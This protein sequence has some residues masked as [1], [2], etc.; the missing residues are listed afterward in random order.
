MYLFCMKHL[1]L[2]LSIIVGTLSPICAYEHLNFRTIDIEKGLSDNL[3]LSITQDQYGFIWLST[4]NG[5]NRYD[6]YNIKHYLT[7]DSGGYHNNIQS[8]DE[9]KAGNLWVKTPS[10]YYYYNRITDRIE[11]NISILLTPL[12]ISTPIEKLVVDENKNLWCASSDSIYLHDFNTKTTTIHTAPQ[13]ERILRIV[14]RDRHAYL[15]CESGNIYK[16]NN[17]NQ[18]LKE[19]TGQLSDYEHHEMYIDGDYNLWIYT[20]FSP[21][22]SIQH[23]NTLTNLWEN[24][25]KEFNFDDSYIVQIIDDLKGNI[26]I[27]TDNK[28]VFIYQAD[29][30]QLDH[31]A[32]QKNQKNSLP[33]NHLGCLYKDNQD[34]IWIGTSKRGAA[35]VNLDKTTFQPLNICAQTDIN[36]LVEDSK[37]NLWLGSDGEGLYRHHPQRKEMESYQKSNSNIPSDVIVC[38]FADSKERLWIGTFGEGIC[39][40]QNN[41][42]TSLKELISDTISNIP[43]YIRSINE[44]DAGNIWI[45]TIVDGL[46]CYTPNGKIHRYTTSNSILPTGSITDLLYN[47]NTLYVA[48]SNGM[49]SID[50]KRGTMNPVSQNSSI[51]QLFADL[52]ITTLYRDSRGL[53]WIGGQ[54]G[55]CVYD[56]NKESIIYHTADKRWITA[57]VKSI[58]EDANHNI[59]I[60]T[61][62]GISNIIV[63]N[64]PEKSIP[65]FRYYHYGEEDGI[66]KQSF[67]YHS[68]LSMQDKSILVGGTNGVIQIH[69]KALKT[70]VRNPKVVFTNLYLSNKAVATGEELP[71]GRVPLKK[72]IQL[73]DELAVDYTDNFTIEVSGMNYDNQHNTAYLYRLNERE[74]W[75]KVSDNKIHFN[76]LHP[77]KYQLEVKM[78]NWNGDWSSESSILPIVVRPPFWQSAW[79]YAMYAILLI[80]GLFYLIY[81]LK[82]RQL[83][84]IEMQRKEMEAIQKNEMDEAKLRFF[85]NISHDLRT[86]LSLI[87]TPLEKMIGSKGKV[88]HE[89]I[90]MVHRNA[91][92]LMNQVSQLLD[93]RKLEEK[94]TEL[95]ASLGNLSLFV[96]EICDDFANAPNDK[97]ILLELDIPTSDVQLSFDRNKMR[98]ILTNLLSNAYKYN[99]TNGKVNV[100]IDPY[101]NKEG[102]SFVRI[103]VEDTGIGIGGENKEKVFNRFFQEGTSTDNIG[104]GL[105][106][107]IVKQFTTMHGGVI[108][109]SDNLPQGTRFTL[110]FPLPT[111]TTQDEARIEATT[112]STLKTLLIVEDN[113]DFRLFLSNSLK[114]H[115][116]ILTACN[117][118]EGMTQLNKNT[119]DIV[120]SDVMMPVMDGLELCSKI[121]N[122]I[123]LSHIPVILLTARTREE[124]IV[125]GLKEGADEYITKP[126]NLDILLLRIQKLLEWKTANHKKFATVDVSP[127]EITISSLDEQLI[128]K[129]LALVEKNMDNTEFTVEDL[130]N[131]VGMTRGHLYKKLMSITGKSPFDFICTLRIKRGKQLLEQSQLSISEIAYRVGFSPKQFA[132]YFKNEYQ[133]LPSE[134]KKRENN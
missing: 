113:S 56:E 116:N 61:D 30:K 58:A 11:K 126:F 128:N 70:I 104:N 7:P 74:D 106:L 105:G 37:G 40:L 13:D 41:R 129:C 88:N 134:Y 19:T 10:S 68:I 23:Y 16:A 14:S 73:L 32:K 120:I 28:G 103:E 100:S 17:D 98:R 54:N 95:N 67:N 65:E 101:T 31:I 18:F 125:E 27:A 112:D 47:K 63:V 50:T 90:V 29:E 127:A 97:N 42:F 62:A 110:T 72:N 35:L 48:T 77:G 115:F 60:T 5:V 45:G 76:R 94:E 108:E 84:K 82:H 9:D 114:K 91:K 66:D 4:S 22:K 92:L 79:A 118:K 43:Q 133:C 69:P 80:S 25:F 36:S 64:D 33:D 89:E 121:K 86:P 131:E 49:V 24:P 99:V 15:L 109:V 130:S 122:S 96:R 39:Y 85:T 78:I 26:W 55:L 3:I 83:T 71:D 6:G 12:G 93:F 87:I 51:N 38:L 52:I 107:H 44:D 81:Y 59:W 132:K 46:Y 1:L 53:L 2:F 57:K 21:E 117:G 20:K 111:A 8:V 124:H 75:M 123:Q 34:N 102:V 119:V